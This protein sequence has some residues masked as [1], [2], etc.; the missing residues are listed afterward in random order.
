MYSQ[1]S[2]VRFSSVAL[3]GSRSIVCKTGGQR[4][5][6]LTNDVVEDILLSSKH[7]AIVVRLLQEGWFRDGGLTASKEQLE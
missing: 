5:R 2:E 7:C 4:R 1:F 6:K 3:A